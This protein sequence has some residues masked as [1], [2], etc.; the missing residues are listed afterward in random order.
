MARNLELELIENIQKSLK[1][2]VGGCGSVYIDDAD[3]HLGNFYCVVTHELTGFDVS[4]CANNIT[5]WPEGE[6]NFYVGPGT[7]LFGNWSAVELLS[8]SITAYT[9]C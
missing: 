9:K 4:E 8:G 2:S 3:T 7:V 6:N 1:E 5:N